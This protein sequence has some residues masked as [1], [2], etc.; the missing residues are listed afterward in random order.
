[1]DCITEGDGVTYDPMRIAFWIAFFA[2]II[3]VNV[4]IGLDIYNTII[5]PATPPVPTKF[6]MVSAATGISAILAAGGTAHF[7]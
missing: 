2:Y 1:M 5:H 4:V 3:G 7:T 6:D